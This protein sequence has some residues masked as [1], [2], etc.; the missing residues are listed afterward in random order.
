MTIHINTILHQAGLHAT[1]D[2]LLTLEHE[3]DAII[4]YVEQLKQVNTKGIKPF[5]H[6][7]NPHQAVREDSPDITNTLDELEAHAPYFE[8]NLFLVPSVR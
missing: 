8:D 7:Q 2:E 6:P 1:D 5:L 3:V 4:N